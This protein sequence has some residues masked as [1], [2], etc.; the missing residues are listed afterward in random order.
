[1]FDRDQAFLLQAKIKYEC[2]KN[3]QAYVLEYSISFMNS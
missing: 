2:K 3:I 1:M